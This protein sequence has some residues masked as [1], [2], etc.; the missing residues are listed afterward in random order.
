MTHSPPVPPLL[1][2]MPAVRWNR[3]PA[4]RSSTITDQRTPV[5]LDAAPRSGD[6]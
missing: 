2:G 5:Q 6:T 3:Q 4:A 1:I